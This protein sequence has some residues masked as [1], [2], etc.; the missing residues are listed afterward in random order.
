MNRKRIFI[1]D[2]EPDLASICKMVLEDEGYEVDEFTDSLLALSKFKPGVYEL[3]ILDIKMPD[4]DG[5]DLYKKIKELDNN[6]KVC[7]LTASEMYYENYRSKEYSLIEEDLF[8]H[9]PI[10]NDE[11]INKIKKIMDS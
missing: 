1:V 11:L 2:D 10:E 4:M 5:F 6:V 7:F 3:I 9:K 8:I